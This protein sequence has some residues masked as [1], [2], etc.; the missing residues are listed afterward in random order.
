MADD[1]FK[2]LINKISDGTMAGTLKWES[3]VHQDAFQVTFK[4]YAVQIRGSDNNFV[5]SLFG[6]RG[7]IL[8]SATDDELGRVRDENIARKYGTATYWSL[9]S[10]VYKA[11]RRIAL[12]TDKAIDDI[13]GQLK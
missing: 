13:L 8:E 2:L 1:K 4:N 9:L 12:G 11:A 10:L 7:E 5:V 3:T 6:D